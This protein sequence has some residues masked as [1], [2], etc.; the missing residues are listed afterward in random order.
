MRKKYMKPIW[1]VADNESVR[2][3]LENALAREDLTT[4]SFFNAREAMNALQTNTPQA[5]VSDAGMPVESGLAL[6]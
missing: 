6:S 5:L 2:R 3:M 1:I 4:R